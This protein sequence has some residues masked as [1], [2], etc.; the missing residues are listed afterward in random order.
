MERSGTRKMS[1]VTVDRRTPHEPGGLSDRALCL[2]LFAKYVGLS[3]YGAWAAVVEIPTFVIVGSSTFAIVWALLV[4]GFA[5]FAAAGIARTWS[6]GKHRLEQWA[7]AA[8]V[9]T[10]LAYSFALVYRAAMSGE[11]STGPLSVIPV[12]VCILP[13]IRFYSLVLRRVRRG[14]E[15]EERQ[16]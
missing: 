3:I 1:S 8:F 12:V 4:S 14:S 11:W 5:V 2:A 13:T 7:A 15:H 9:L 6:T 16:A 10:F